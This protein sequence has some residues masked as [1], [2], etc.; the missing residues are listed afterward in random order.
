MSFTF[1]AFR[2]ELTDEDILDDLLYPSRP[3]GV[4][5]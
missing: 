2:I 4:A 5:R 1:P 3:D